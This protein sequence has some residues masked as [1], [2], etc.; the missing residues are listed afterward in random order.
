MRIA[1]LSNINMNFVIRGLKLKCEVYE[2]EGYGNELGIM[3]N[4]GSSYHSFHPQIT[5]LVMDLGELICRETDFDCARKLVLRW[6]EDLKSVILPGKIYYISDVV[7]NGFSYQVMEDG[8]FAL[9]LE[10]L[11][12]DELQRLCKDHE[13]VRAFPYRKILT[14][15]G[16]DNAYSYKT[17]YLGKILLSSAAQNKLAREILERVRVE[18]YVPKKVLVLDLD[19]TLW[20]GLAGEADHTPIKLSEE[21]EGLAYKNLQRVVLQ[22]QKQGVLLTIVSKNN[23]E[24]A[25]AVINDH[26][27]MVLRK[28]AFAAYRINWLP[29]HENIME[30]SKELNLGLDSFVF[31]DDNPTER[32]LVH[33]ML[34]MVTV[35]EFPAKPEELAPA[36]VQI[37]KQ[38]FTRPRLTKED[39]VK[40]EQ[41]LENQ[42]RQELKAATVSF[43]EYLE[44][45]QICIKKADP[46]QEKQRLLQ[47]LNK[48]N[49]FNLTTRRHTSEEL[50][51]ILTDSRREVFFYGVKD[52][53]GDNGL[54]A[55]L[56]VDYRDIPTIEEFV[57][58]C[59][60]MGRNIEMA[61]LDHVEQIYQK[62]GYDTLRARFVPS[63]R[64]KPVEKL[65]E[66][67]GYKHVGEGIFELTLSQKPSRMYRAKVED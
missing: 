39:L 19:N 22:M 48:T 30:L 24:D 14:S 66:D 41:Y 47:L 59:R 42:K 9:S 20:G 52:C 54:V 16:E 17:W 35:P 61:I 57:M 36:M 1:L 4:P 65:Y 15:L 11:W 64:N 43:E 37:Y 18:T 60:V 38:Y 23:L 21:K 6:F 63:G 8:A 12:V 32:Q 56:I 49:Q 29:K 34:P 28:E 7:L 58:S 44:K 5:F 55:A 13:N 62:K 46:I 51:E 2:P 10:K 33:E 53:Y 27:H 25:L 40:T 45:L 50:E 26:P 67:L 3:L 31:W